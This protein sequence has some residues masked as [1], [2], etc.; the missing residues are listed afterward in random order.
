[1]SATETATKTRKRAGQQQRFDAEG[2]PKPDEELEAA[3]SAYAKSL[4][5]ESNAKQKKTSAKDSLVEVMQR[6]GV[7]TVRFMHGTTEKMIRIEH[8]DSVKI[9]TVKQS[10]SV[11]SNDSDDE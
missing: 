5:A 1:V 9:E 3:A 10:S 6:K 4:T 7:E 8:K 2:F 11:D